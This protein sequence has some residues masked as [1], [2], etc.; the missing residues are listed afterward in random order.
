MI[1]PTA[2]TVAARHVSNRSAHSPP[3][4]RTSAMPTGPMSACGETAGG[5]P[6]AVASDPKAAATARTGRRMSLFLRLR[7]RPRHGDGQFVPTRLHLEGDAGG[8]KPGVLAVH[9]RPL[10]FGKLAVAEGDRHDDDAV[11]TRKRAVAC[12]FGPPAKGAVL[13]DVALHPDRFAVHGGL[14]DDG[15]GL[16]RTAVLVGHPPGDRITSRPAPR[17]EGQ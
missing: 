9:G 3:V 17:G 4:Q 7:L 15:P 6:A 11:V 1:A 12:P 8:V 16:D 13:P 5:W 10:P 2:G 14:A